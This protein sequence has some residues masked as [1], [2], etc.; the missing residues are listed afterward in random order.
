[1]KSQGQIVSTEPCPNCL[2]EGRD[3]AGDNLTVYADGGKYCHA[4]GESTKSVFID[5]EITALEKRGLDYDTSKH[6]QVKVGQYT[7]MVGTGKKKRKCQDEFVKIFTWFDEHGRP[8]MQ[9]IKTQFKEMTLKGNTKNLELWGKTACQITD[10]LFITI[11]EGEEDAMA[12]AQ[13]QGCQYPVVSLP[14]GCSSARTVLESELQYL[15]KFKHVVLAFDNDEAGRE[16]VQDCLASDLF[17]PGK[18]KVATW[19]KKDA[20]E[21]LLSGLKDEIT[22]CLF[23]AKVIEPD[24]I[25]T[26]ADIIDKVME[27]PKFGEAYP[28]SAMTEITYGS[29]LGEIHIVVGPTGVGK[30]EFIKD[31]LFHFIDQNINAGL[32]S[33]EQNPDNTIRRLVG[34]KQGVKLHLPGAKW[35]SAKIKHQAMAFNERIYLYDKAGQVDLQDIFHSIRYMA[36]AK[37]VKYFVVDNLKAIGV[38][39]DNEK[40]QDLMNGLKTLC[41]D[42][43]ITVFLLSHVAKDKYGQT[44]YTTTSPQNPSSYFGKSAEERDENLKLPGMDWESGRMPKIEN[45][46]GGNIIT[47][48]ADY[49][50]GLARNT[51]AEDREEAKIVR[52]KA[53][54]TRLDSSFTG[55]VFKL[56]Y[57][58]EGKLEELDGKNYFPNQQDEET[59]AF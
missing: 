39:N 27:Q 18:V 20:N 8:K 19:L 46:E 58:T 29:Q 14:N 41:K 7:G 42:L 17:E 21:M 24:H 16:A 34:A 43:N 57:T 55:K 59:R 51:T 32:F 45:V 13:V 25:V 33:F 44:V 54:K 38:A 37:S 49:V 9:K 11:T 35:D 22:H 5:G 31:I 50:W 56:Y 4:C 47:S 26:V 3:S 15:Q 10:K 6:Y 28:W 23:N 1:M 40:A 30:T 53:L 48:L 36:K 2:L 52:I 12:V